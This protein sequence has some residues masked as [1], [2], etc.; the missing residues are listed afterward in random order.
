MR[1]P[2]RARVLKRAALITAPPKGNTMDKLGIPWKSIL[3]FLGVFAGQLW[4][5]AAVNGVPVV[6]DTLAGWGALI[7]GSFIA[8]IGV[9]LKANIYTIDQAQAKVADAAARSTGRHAL[10]E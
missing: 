6:P 10:P 7:G 4:A 9:Y 1:Q 3:A 8:A 2:T 5:R